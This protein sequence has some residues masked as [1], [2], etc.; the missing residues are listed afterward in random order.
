MKKIL[1]TGSTAYDVLLGYD[2]SFADAIDP[3]SIKNLSVSFFS[4]HYARHHGGTGANIAWTLRLLGGSPLLVSTVGADGGE[5]AAL[6]RERGL[7]TTYLEK[8]NSYVTATAIIGTDTASRQI[9]FFH[10]GA[11]AHGTWPGKKLQEERDD[12]A[13]A[14]VGARNGSLMTEAARWCGKWKVPLLFDPAQQIIGLSKDDLLA[15]IRVST[16]VICNAYEWSIL[17]EKT[18]LN[19]DGVLEHAKYLIVTHGGDGLT[20]YA[21][22]GEHVLP[23]CKA[24]KV[25]NPTGAGDALR[26]GLL[27][28]LGAGWSLEDA[29]KLG[30]AVA[31]FVVEQEGTLLDVLD[32]D[33]VRNRAQMAYGKA[34]PELS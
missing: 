32:I 12:L 20:L 33:E 14:I 1:I 4:P 18:G 31:S 5:Y 29:S 24:D 17:S 8:L 26:A 15:G 11:D 23:A 10:P 13:Y 34:L 19:A 16:G 3:K 2:G 9:A 22:K 28:G 25:V 21:R 7:D 6:L 30:A 27:A